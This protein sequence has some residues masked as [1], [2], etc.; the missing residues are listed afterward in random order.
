M[1]LNTKTSNKIKDKNQQ[2]ISKGALITLVVCISLAVVAAIVLSIYFTIGFSKSS[3]LKFSGVYMKS[4][5]YVYDGSPKSVDVVGA[6]EGTNIKYKYE[7]KAADGATTK[8]EGNSFTESG[9][10]KVVATLSK[11]GYQDRD[12]TATV[13]ITRSYT[14]TFRQEGYADVVRSVEEGGT[15]GR[16][17]IP[18]PKAK[19][20][21]TVAWEDL[22]LNNITRDLVVRAVERL[23]TYSVEYWERSDS[24]W[25]NPNAV[26][27]TVLSPDF[28]LASPTREGCEFLG[29]FDARGERVVSLPDGRAENL[30]LKAEWLDISSA[31][32]NVEFSLSGTYSVSG[33]DYDDTF[34]YVEPEQ[35]EK[36]EPLNPGESIPDSDPDKIAS[37]EDP[38]ATDGTEVN[39]SD[40]VVTGNGEVVVGEKEI[41]IG[42]EKE[43][44]K[45]VVED[46][47]GNKVEK[48]LEEIDAEKYSP[49][50]A[51]D[52]LLII[53]D[54]Y[55]GVAVS[56]IN[57]AVFKK[58][59]FTRAYIGKNV[60]EIGV[61]SFRSCTYLS[62]VYGCEK[63][64]RLSDSA[65]RGSGITSFESGELTY[66]GDRAFAFCD[67]LKTVDSRKITY[68]GEN[69][70][71][72]CFALD[73]LYINK[74]IAYIGENA[75]KNC[76]R[77]TIVFD[78]TQKEWEDLVSSFGG[79]SYIAATNVAVVTSDA[80]AEIEVE[81]LQ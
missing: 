64:E 39:A 16:S 77:L 31:N 61:E 12:I 23:Y 32:E 49:K 79:L 68:I 73:E 43:P 44:E 66:L 30:V 74:D 65:F 5:E 71:E 45:V 52:D 2:K 34:V 4:A 67:A 8:G 22:S 9:V 36:V 53:P 78:G 33:Y 20:G 54:V 81:V 38:T 10:Y 21:Y 18:V 6:P 58:T 29:W 13:K 1:K 41:D 3:K 15:L 56:K 63:V 60:V 14:V 57:D 80:D 47:S 11:K 19:K 59:D 48:T 35:P 7:R 42:G 50:K 51:T 46:G 76:N 55:N 69:C 40:K 24:T 17:S 75:F 26:T 37:N 72:N 62:S 28:E 25:V 27:Y 70:F